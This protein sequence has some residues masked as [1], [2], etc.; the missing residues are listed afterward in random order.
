MLS[1]RGKLDWFLGSAM[2][3]ENLVAFE[4]MDKIGKSFWLLDAAFR[5][6]RAR[7]RVAYFEAGD[8]TRD[9]VLERLGVRAARRPLKAGPLLIPASV[10]DGGKVESE[11]RMFDGD[12]TP[13]EAYRAF[14]RACRGRDA[15]RL[16]CHPNSTLTVDDVAATLRDWERE[17]WTADV[18]VIDYADILAPPAGVRDVLDQ[19]DAVWKQLRRL[20]QESHC[21]VVTATQPSA[22]AYDN[23]GKV[24]TRRHFGGRKTK[25]AHVNGLIGLNPGDPCGDVSVTRVNWIVRRGAEFRENRW[26]TVAG[27]LALAAPA[28]RCED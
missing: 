20:S 8:L 1:Y 3:R 19:I 26:V 9:D 11:N 21:L 24:L 18:V 10:S 12:L 4:G 22:K 15:F 14:R 13:Q 28:M 5:A 6:V 2:L 27:S 7:R 23:K 16:S 25:L 17:G